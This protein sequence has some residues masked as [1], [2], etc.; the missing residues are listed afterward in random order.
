MQNY[1][2]E[3]LKPK[4]LIQ[5]DMDGVDTEPMIAEV[6]AQGMEVIPITHSFGRHFDFNQYNS[7]DCIVC[8]GDIDFIRQATQRAKFVPGA[9]CNFENMKCST[10]YAYFGEHLLNKDYTM[11][12]LGDLL[13]RWEDF[14]ESLFVRPD[15]GVKS[16]TG[17]VV[18]HN[19]KD[20]IRTLI[21]TVGPDVL[22]V[23][24]SKKDIVAEYRFVICNR[25]VVAG[26]TY[27]PY[28]CPDYFRF[29]EILA[30][31]IAEH[32]WQP[33]LC[34]TVDIAEITNTE[35]PR[36]QVLMASQFCLL[37]INSF[38][39]AGFYGCDIPCIVGYASDAA[40]NEWNEYCA[41]S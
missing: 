12:P 31:N 13:R 30:M 28:E 3:S 20:K 36:E 33:D 18:A 19:E 26:C 35:I 24:A 17:F 5:T 37:E 16:F 38:S 21:Q 29:P 11:M 27:L 8:Y 22:V 41:P 1:E 7:D 10:Y 14:K 40:M 39:C 2:T 32:E 34:Y 25:K 9:W 6:K 23:V 4:W 15:S